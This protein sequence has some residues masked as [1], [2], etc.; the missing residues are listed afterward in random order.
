MTFTTSKWNVKYR[1]G[2]S[3]E[4][5]TIFIRQT[6]LIALL[7]LALWHRSEL[8]SRPVVKLPL[9]LSVQS[10]EGQVVRC[11]SAIG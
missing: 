2:F 9:D 1:R 11:V 8:L 5:Y 3:K 4:T 7:R 10:T 6:L